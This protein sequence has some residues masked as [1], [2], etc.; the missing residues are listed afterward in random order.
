MRILTTGLIIAILV[1]LL[2]CGDSQLRVNDSAT[3][4]TATIVVA[5]SDSSAAG[6]AQADY[7]C[8]GS[9]DQVEIQAAIDALPSTGGIIQLSE[10]TFNLASVDGDHSID[11]SRDNV[12]FRG[13]GMGATKLFIGNGVRKNGIGAVNSA[14]ITISDLE[15]DGNKANNTEGAPNGDSIQNGIYFR[16]VDYSTI[17][18]VSSHDNIFHGIFLVGDSDYNRVVN[19]KL[20][21]N[22]YRG[23]HA[24]TSVDY[25]Y[26][27]YNYLFE[28]GDGTGTYGGL[29]V[30]FNGATYNIIE[31]NHIEATKSTGVG[32]ID[33]GGGSAPAFGNVIVGNIIDTSATASVHGIR[34]VNA[35]NIYETTITGNLIRAS[36]YGILVEDGTPKGTIIS[37][38]SIYAGVRGIYV[39]SGGEELVISNNIIRAIAEE[40]ISLNRVTR[41]TISGNL[42]KAHSTVD[43]L[44]M[45]NCTDN[46]IQANN[47]YDVKYAIAEVG[48]NSGNIIKDNRATSASASPAFNLEEDDLKR[49][50]NY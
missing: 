7:V 42:M 18:R 17:E 46:I 39:V 14:N 6:K 37:N 19:N 10:G 50:D 8:D 35:D 20:I 29:F 32:G 49:A 28:N 16:N 33:I 11:L 21:R 45:K 3:P 44:E 12:I 13:S 23:I 26:Y 30:I 1:S 48:G 47:F 4:R 41:S 15:I 5:A 43:G 40:A 38:N 34:F 36:R 22:R 9:D 24:H 25:N 2:G 31:G 27:G